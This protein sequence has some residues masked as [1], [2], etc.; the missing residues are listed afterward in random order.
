MGCNGNISKHN[1]C[2]GAFVLPTPGTNSIGIQT[3]C[4]A[5]RE[6]ARRAEIEEALIEERANR[7]AEDPAPAVLPGLGIMVKGPDGVFRRS[8]TRENEYRAK[9]FAG[10]VEKRAT[11]KISVC[12]SESCT[13]CSD[14]NSVDY[15]KNF[16]VNTQGVDCI[17]VT[18]LDDAHISYW[19]NENCN[20]RITQYHNCGTNWV[21]LSAPGTNSVGIQTGC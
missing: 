6:E 16:C 4:I 19:N 7:T 2:G 10:S 8:E 15:D 17:I 11:A 5:K 13:A 21:Q 20:G 9:Y 3:G 1:G 14:I 18:E 12:Q